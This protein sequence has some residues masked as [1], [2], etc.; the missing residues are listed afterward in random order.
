MISWFLNNPGRLYVLATLLP[1]AAFLLLLL[2]GLVRALA[3]TQRSISPNA[4]ALYYLCGGDKPLRAGAYIATAAIAL[5]A[6]LAVT[7]LVNF[8]KD[9]NDDALTAEKLQARWS[10]RTVWV[11]IGPIDAAAVNKQIKDEQDAEEVNRSLRQWSQA[12]PLYAKG[13]DQAQAL[14]LEL[15]YRIDHLTAILFAMVTVISTGIFLFSIGYMRDELD[16]TVVDHEVPMPAAAAADHGHGHHEQPTAHH[17]GAHWRRRGRYGRFFLYLSL[18]CFSML[19]LVIADNLFQVFISWELVGVCSF[20]LIGFYYERLSASTAA[21]KAFIVNRIGDAGFVVGLAIFWAYF[22]TFN[23]E[24][25]QAKL[26]CPS[27]DAHYAS[28]PVDKQGTIVRGNRFTVPGR[29]EKV[30]IEADG[31]FA[32][33]FPEHWHAGDMHEGG[34]VTARVPVQ[35]DSDFSTIP[36]WLLIVAGLGIFLGCVGKSAQF[37]L[38]TWLPDAME[39]PTP[40]SALI[41][42]ATMVAAGVYLVGRAY[43][44]FTP[45]V[46]LIIAYTGAVTLFLAATIA[47]VQT[48]IKR[49]LAY[50]TVSQLGYMMLALGVG[51][52]APGL[53]HL[54]THAFFKALLFLAAGAVIF[55]LHHQQDLRKMGGLR[56]KM[57]ITAY[58]ML[59]GVLAIVGTPLFSGW[60]SK[61]QIIGQ[62]LAFGLDHPPHMA[63]AIL[64]LVTAALTGFYMFR[65]WLLA[66]AGAPRDPHTFEHAHESPW[67]MTIPLIV[68]AIFSVGVGWGEKFWKPDGSLIGETLQRYQPDV[69]HLTFAH[70]IH[71]AHEQHLLAGALALAAAILG[72]GFAIWTYGLG[73]FELIKLQ[74]WFGGVHTFLMRKWYFDELYDALFVIPT[75]KLAFFIGRFDKRS[76]APELAEAADRRIDPSSVDG[77]IS[78]VGLLLYALGQRLRLVQSGLLRNYILVLV[79]TTVMMF[80]I[81]SFLIV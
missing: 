80:A 11:Q 42:A 32:L 41:H 48:D 19:N 65:L 44:L 81:L 30:R 52:W 37:P 54:I 43:P 67:V 36:Y 12:G 73:K 61:D 70:T 26:R 18:F 39:G 51:A 6:A 74:A 50:S 24:E 33:I 55:G 62:A 31:K 16:E 78:A 4:S 34:E 58:T 38:H 27:H 14:T 77:V 5:S 20:F 25:I 15:G 49:V 68:L 57:P 1:L 35:R 23:F 56:R 47:L 76:V 75:V 79:L 53:L 7:G 9:V 3:R 2:G 40:V 69:V 28:A 60:Y 63:L 72:A 22:G 13:R 71:T 21:N 17:D 64:P 45:E 46:L 8:L 29:P 10:E 59:A 66:F